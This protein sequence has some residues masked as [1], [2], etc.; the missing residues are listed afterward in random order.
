MIRSQAERND[1]ALCH[2]WILR[3]WAACFM[4]PPAYHTPVSKTDDWTQK[5][6]KVG[7]VLYIS[8]NPRYVATWHHL[9][10]CRNAVLMVLLGLGTKYTCLGSGK[11]HVLAKGVWA[12][13]QLPKLVTL[14]CNCKNLT[15]YQSIHVFPRKKLL[16]V[17]RR[18]RYRGL[19]TAMRQQNTTG[20]ETTSCFAFN[21]EFMAWMI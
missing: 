4:A 5:P 17:G 11:D 20:K 6:F 12:S 3:S 9:S 14:H 2:L 10:L 1:R 13:E 19:C 16:N 15:G 7:T 18:W 21:A 8:A